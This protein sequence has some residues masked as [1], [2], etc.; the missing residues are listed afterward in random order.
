[1]ATID[2]LESIE[3]CYSAINSIL[4]FIDNEYLQMTKLYYKTHYR[5]AD[6]KIR[7]IPK[8]DVLNL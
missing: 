5:Q 3:K 1:M 2:K 8:V 6:N 7:Y 4:Y